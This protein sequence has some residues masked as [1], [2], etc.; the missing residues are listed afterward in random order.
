MDEEERRMEGREWMGRSVGWM[1]KEGRQTTYR[2]YR[3]RRD[4]PV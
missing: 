3:M 4:K 1:G 2:D